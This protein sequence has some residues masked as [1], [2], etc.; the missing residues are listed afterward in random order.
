M[1]PFSSTFVCQN[2]DYLIYLYKHTHI[3]IKKHKKTKRAYLTSPT[4]QPR[5][6]RFLYESGFRG[7]DILTELWYNVYVEKR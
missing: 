7:I 4:K 6:K 1:N 2:I 3:Y 5:C